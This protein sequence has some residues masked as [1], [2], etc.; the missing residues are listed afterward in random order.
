MAAVGECHI[1]ASRQRPQHFR[2]IALLGL[3]EDK[4]ERLEWTVDDWN[5]SNHVEERYATVQVVVLPELQNDLMN[6]QRIGQWNF[7][8]FRFQRRQS[9]LADLGFFFKR[10]ASKPLRLLLDKKIVERV[11]TFTRGRAVRWIL[12]NQ[13]NQKIGKAWIMRRK[14]IS[15]TLQSDFIR[16]DSAPSSRT[17][18][19][20]REDGVPR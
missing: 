16:H 12:M 1:K 11:D 3:F 13:S 20:S 4:L 7:R 2:V 15:Q 14:R 9:F 5:A 18:D 19:R 6:A 17:M 8:L 10:L